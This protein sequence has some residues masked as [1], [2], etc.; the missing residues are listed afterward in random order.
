VSNAIW[1][2]GIADGY[3]IG[4]S[5]NDGIQ[6]CFGKGQ[7][8]TTVSAPQTTVAAGTSILIQ[9]TV[10]DQSPAQPNTPAISDADMGAWMDYVHMQKPLVGTITGV[11]VKLSAIA[12]DGT[13]IDIGTVTSD[14]AGLF[15]KMWSPPSQGAYTIVAN[16]TGSESYWSSAAETAI[17][18]GPAS[19]SG[20]TSPSVSPSVSVSTSPQ[21]GASQTT[22]PS[23]SSS[24]SA[25]VSAS[26]SVAPPPSSTAA[27]SMTL[28]IAI[29]AVAIVIAA[30]A[31]AV[32]LKRKK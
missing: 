16:F 31:V 4:N 30:V 1:P 9:G 12:P 27:P 10:M 13:V 3:L 22:S 19:S 29:A 18:V 11:P 20:S 14:S 6:Y 21:P 7:T 2:A 32:A 25:S 15:K 23:A 24:A 26:P 17:G 28:Y 5:E 8:A